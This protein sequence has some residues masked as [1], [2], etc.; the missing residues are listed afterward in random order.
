MPVLTRY[1][2][3]S[4]RY[5]LTVHDL[6]NTQL[7]ALDGIVTKQSKEWLNHTGHG[8]S[9]AILHSRDGLQFKTV[10]ELYKECNV[11]AH[12]SSRLGADDKVQNALDSKVLRESKWSKK[13]SQCNAAVCEDYVEKSKDVNLK[14]TN[15]LA[16][17]ATAPNDRQPKSLGKEA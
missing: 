13:M 9:P 6:T 3:P 10:S 12:A 1:S 16:H 17:Y 7:S 11:L 14:V 2:L 5:V 15:V 4:L 8:A